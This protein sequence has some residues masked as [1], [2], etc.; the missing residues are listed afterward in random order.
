MNYGSTDRNAVSDP[1]RKSESTIMIL[2]LTPLIVAAFVLGG[3]FLG[4]Y[5]SDMLGIPKFVLALALST[6]GLFAS[7][8]VVVKFVSWMIRKESREKGDRRK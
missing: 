3:L 7:L 1:A 2:A 6:G 5:L 8:P 4:L